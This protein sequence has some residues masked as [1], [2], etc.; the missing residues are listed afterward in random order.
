M[1]KLAA[2][3]FKAHG[4]R[5]LVVYRHLEEEQKRETQKDVITKENIK[6]FSS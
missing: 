4:P 5:L 3:A 6:P 2:P 1:V